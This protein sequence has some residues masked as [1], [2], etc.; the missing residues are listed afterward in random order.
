MKRI[1][2]YFAIGSL[3]LNSSCRS[4]LVSV[5]NRELGFKQDGEMIKRARPVKGPEKKPEIFVRQKKLSIAPIHDENNSGSLYNL[6]DPRNILLTE[7]PRGLIGSY[8]DIGVTSSRVDLKQ[9]G[10]P[11]T[12]QP[13][14][15]GELEKKI[16]EAFPDLDAGK[17]NPILLKSIKVH[18]AGRLPN[19]DALVVMSRSSS[20]EGESN[21]I[22]VAAK[23]PYEVLA[24][25]RPITTRDLYD[26]EWTESE[27]GEYFARKSSSWEDEY[28]LRISGFSEAKSKAALALMDKKKQL[29]NIQ[30]QM[31]TQLKNMTQQRVKIAQERGRLQ[32]IRQAHAEE[33]SKLN[34]KL[35]EKDSLL[36][37][38]SRS[39]DELKNEKKELEAQLKE[40]ENKQQVQPDGADEGG[41]EE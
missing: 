8:L 5:T 32:S 21:S 36:E 3:L 14:E 4:G 22:N 28:T 35:G 23:I 10:Q 31:Q 17:N 7:K 33:K 12:K 24:S 2:L 9:E 41:G 38:Q 20:N 29:K 39:I 40:M 30:K 16:L 25:K 1:L 27:D 11:E 13:P 6:E 34:E 15:G 37:E 18:I 26:V 19:G